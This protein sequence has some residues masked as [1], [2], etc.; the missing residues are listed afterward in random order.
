VARNGSTAT[1]LVQALAKESGA[2]LA[3]IWLTLQ[4]PVAANGDGLRSWSEEST[5]LTDRDG[6]TSF[7]VPSERAL[8]YELQPDAGIAAGVH[9]EVPALAPGEQRE[10]VVR[11]PTLSDV[12]WFG[13]VLDGESRAPLGNARVLITGDPFGANAGRETAR[14]AADG[15]VRLS[16][17]SWRSSY[18]RVDSDGYATGF[19][20]LDGDHAQPASAF[21]VRLLRVGTLGLSV[22]DRDG[23][24]REALEVR[25]SFDALER[26]QGGDGT[27]TEAP[28]FRGRTDAA[29]QCEI[30]GLPP[31]IAASRSSCSRMEES[32]VARAR[33]GSSRASGAS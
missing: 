29:G 30:G 3:E 16:F 8:E 19:V 5:Y 33:C 6:R 10:I 18:A 22:T 21:P 25:V 31:E 9:L 28:S 26:L 13:Q 27:G 1:L 4:Q 14:T 23:A 17:A 12:T 2:P 20:H 11:L 24:P 7:T 15:I 32:C